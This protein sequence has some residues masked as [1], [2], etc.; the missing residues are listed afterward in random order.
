M[1]GRLDLTSLVVGET[2][3]AMPLRRFLCVQDNQC[4]NDQENDGH[5]ANRSM[6]AALIALT[7][8]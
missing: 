2:F 8:V 1:A 3:L 6:T 4:G 7:P 5:F